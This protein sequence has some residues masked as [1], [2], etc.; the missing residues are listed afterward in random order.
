MSYLIRVSNITRGKKIIVST[1]NYQELLIEV[2]LDFELDDQSD[3]S[4][5][6]D[7]G[8]EIGEKV[9]SFFVKQQ[10]T[11]NIEFLVKGEIQTELTVNPTTISPI[12][13]LSQQYAQP[14]GSLPHYLDANYFTQI[15]EFT[16]DNS[17]DLKQVVADCNRKGCV[18][19]SASAIL[20]NAF[21][22]KLL[23]VKGETPSSADQ[24]L[25]AKA[26]VTI[27]PCWK[28]SLSTEGIVMIFYLTR[29]IGQVPSNPDCGLSVK[30]CISRLQNRSVNLPRKGG[31]AAKISKQ[32]SA[33]IT[34]FHENLVTELN[35]ST[36][37]G[38]GPADIK[39]LMEKTVG[40]RNHLRSVGDNSILKTYTKFA[41]CD[42]MINYEFF[43]MHE[44][45]SNN[46][47]SNWDKEIGA[48]LILLHLIPPT[49]QGKGKGGRC[50]IDGAKGRIITFHKTGTP[51]QSIIDTWNKEITQPNLL[52]LG[53]SSSKLSSFFV[54]CDGVLIPVATQNTTEAI[55][56]LFKAHYVF[57]TDYD[58]NLK[59]L[60]KFLQVYVYNLDLNSQ[61]PTRVKVI[62]SRELQN[63]VK[64]VHN[65]G[66]LS[67]KSSVCPFKNCVVELSSWSGYL[68]HIKT[69]D[70]VPVTQNNNLSINLG[71]DADFCSDLNNYEDEFEVIT[72]EDQNISVELG[73]SLLVRKL[74]EVCGSLLGEG[75]NNSTID[76]IVKELEHTFSEVT[77]I[78][79]KIGREYCEKDF[80]AFSSKTKSLLNA[81]EKVVLLTGTVVGV[82]AHV[83]SRW[84]QEWGQES[85]REYCKALKHPTC[86][87]TAIRMEIAFVAITITVLI[88]ASASLLVTPAKLRIPDIILH[89]LAALL[90]A[91]AGTL[92]LVSATSINS[93][94]TAPLEGS[95]LLYSLYTKPITLNPTNIS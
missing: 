5:Q 54:I 6:D 40:H 79:L 19:Q 81:F 27:L 42:F 67:F 85:F 64:Y 74:G 11:P 62:S 41:E 73:I 59:G 58:V 3:I 1:D 84:T 65:Y 13:Y 51:L 37:K 49:A 76:F 70:Y 35:S 2:K 28:Y 56:S 93:Y 66:H 16:L 36:S 92:I 21:V 33:D 10:A 53:E 14:S 24:K 63:Y 44:N 48:L 55:D 43:L 71:V 87:K 29:L 86:P 38:G 83:T 60:W 34:S 50:K 82:N 31:P 69:H 18:D 91:A 15:L 72:G 94:L 22:A 47:R 61:L 39:Q 20:I 95:G 30:T 46:F 17:P 25:L 12:V 9:F 52:C 89:G 7:Q 68:R 4:L 57:G 26:I 45:E 77:D 90:L 75:I 8:A 78:I 23:E 32:V 80:Q 88:S